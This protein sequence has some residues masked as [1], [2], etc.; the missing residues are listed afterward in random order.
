MPEFKIILFCMMAM[1]W[2]MPAWAVPSVK[3]LDLSLPAEGL[4][5]EDHNLPM[6]TLQMNFTYAGALSDPADKAGRALLAASLLNEGAGQYDAQAFH[7]ALEAKAIQLSASSGQDNLTISLKTLSQNLPQAI[8]LL[9]QMLTQ[10][11][12]DEKSFEQAKEQQLSV[13]RQSAQDPAWH[14]WR[15]WSALAYA[16]HPYAQPVQGTE[17]T[18]KD[19][20]R[21]DAVLWHQSVLG[22][23][24]LKL[25]VVGDTTVEELQKS[26]S[27]LIKSLPQEAAFKIPPKAEPIA[28]GKPPVVV[29]MEVPQT[30]VLFA[31][32]AVPR[33]SPDFYAA[34]L[35]NHILGGG[36]LVSRLSHAIREEK[37]LAYSVG[38]NLSPDLLDSTLQGMFA[39]RNEQVAEAVKTLEDTLTKYARQGATA[40]ELQN[41]KNYITGSFPLELDSQQARAGFLSAMLLYGLG[42]DYLEKR[43][44]YFQNVS[45]ADVNRMARKLLSQAPLTV[46][47]GNP[48]QTIEWTK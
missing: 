46:L 22:Q 17:A 20:T 27:P 26:L 33:N 21:E 4:L 48:P 24:R 38:T 7:Q 2:A 8:L 39:T 29:K 42:D 11:R 12:F 47:A 25:A 35:M 31:F 13:I 36:S 16:N 34:Y 1:V 14:A 30:I 32:P 18:V 45:L 41:A 9:T 6:V 23:N 15:K 28:P 5:I 3:R 37:G 44:R 10:P 43:N 19:L 40:E